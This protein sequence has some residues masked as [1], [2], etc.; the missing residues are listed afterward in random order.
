M[1]TF[2]QIRWSRRQ[3]GRMLRRSILTHPERWKIEAAE[4]SLTS[5]VDREFRIVLEPRFIRVFDA[6][7]VY[8]DDAE[9][10]LPVMPRIRLRNAARWL[11]LRHAAGRR[12]VRKNLGRRLTDRRAVANGER[13]A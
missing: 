2:L 8:C 12:P 3:V 5:L 11:L 10:W 4:G 1:F 7:H 13:A 9:V 6:I